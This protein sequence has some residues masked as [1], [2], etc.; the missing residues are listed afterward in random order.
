MASRVVDIHP[1]IIA[2][3]RA[4][5]P[6]DPLFGVQSGWSKE[7]PVEIDGLIAEMNEAGVDKAAV[8]Q[9]STCFGFDNS[10]VTDSIAHHKGR[11]TGVGSI[12]L[13]A[14]DATIALDFAL[15][16][17]TGL[18]DRLIVYPANMQRNLEI[19]RGLYHSQTILLK[20]TERGLERKTA[21]EAVQR[22]AMKP[23]PWERMAA[24]RQI[25]IRFIVAE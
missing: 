2:T 1:H 6:L 25:R 15:A 17:L 20:L 11:L 12:N 3:D 8:V 24:D 21:Y 7:R 18:I 13:I 22:A 19:T 14:P 5:Y 4:R 23:Q 9:A 10:Y 16:R